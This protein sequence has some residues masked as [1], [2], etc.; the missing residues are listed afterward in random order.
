MFV[1]LPVFSLLSIDPLW[2]TAWPTLELQSGEE[3]T[4]TDPCSA[5]NSQIWQVMES[6]IINVDTL[7]DTSKT[8]A[9]RQC[10]W[11]ILWTLGMLVSHNSCCYICKTESSLVWYRSE[12]PKRHIWCYATPPCW[13]KRGLEHES[14]HCSTL[15]PLE[16]KYTALHCNVL[17]LTAFYFIALK[18]S[19]QKLCFTKLRCLALHQSLHG[20]KV[21][22]PT[23]RGMWHVNFLFFFKFPKV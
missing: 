23:W 20:W 22:Y 11:N 12:F 21:L 1:N 3:T 2:V 13:A 17:K 9:V 19:V 10:V 15:P 18:Y 14:Q 5:D 4:D 16:L 6:M 7:L 8:T